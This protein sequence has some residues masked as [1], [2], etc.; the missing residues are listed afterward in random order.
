MP[1]SIARP[2]MLAVAGLIAILPLSAVSCSAAQKA[3]DC[4]NTAV[5]ITGDINEVSNAYSNA[6][7]DSAAA[8]QALQKLKNDL[9]QL[10]KNSKDTDVVQAINDLNAQVD[11]VQQTVN[12]K[13]VPDFKPLGSAASNLTKVCTG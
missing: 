9:D 7:N 13:Q 8:G 3:L 11:K 4:G 1:Q 5:K 12:N 6:S 2:T 10:G